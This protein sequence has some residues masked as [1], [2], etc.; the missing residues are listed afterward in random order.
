VRR[1]A[2]TATLGLANRSVRAPP[3]RREG[4]MTTSLVA[5][6]VVGI[7]ALYF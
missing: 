5:L 2:R 3:G 1:F 6:I 7:I 4:T